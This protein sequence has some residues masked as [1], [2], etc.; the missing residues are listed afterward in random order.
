[1]FIDRL[2]NQGNAPVLEQVARFTETRHKLLAD[3]IV[4]INTPGY[5]ARD[6]SVKGFQRML[7]DRVSQRNEAAPGSVRFDDVMPA[8]EDPRRGVLF[9]DGQTRSVEQLMSEFSKNALMHNM[10]VEMLRRQY[11]ALEMAL[12]LQPA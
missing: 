8:A 1:M 7:G 11:S 5:R 12:K 9:H 10:A 2:L 3:N 6:V 4:N